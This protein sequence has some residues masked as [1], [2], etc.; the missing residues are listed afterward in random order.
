MLLCKAWNQWPEMHRFMTRFLESG[1]AS[2]YDIQILLLRAHRQN[3]PPTNVE[4][5]LERLGD[6]GGRCSRYNTLIRAAVRIPMVAVGVLE[7]DV[8]KT[9]VAQ[10]A[11]RPVHQ[12]PDALDAVHFLGKPG[13]HCSLITAAGAEFKHLFRNTSFAQQF[14]HAR[15]NER[16]GYRLSKSDR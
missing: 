9:Q 12:W 6:T 10:R 4:L 11:A 16:A 14:G 8:E 13:E 7:N 5:L 1:F 3:Q 2:I 15:H